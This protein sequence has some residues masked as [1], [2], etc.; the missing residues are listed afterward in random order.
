MAWPQQGQ[1]K[2]IQL[3]TC[4]GIS[5]CLAQFK[6]DFARKTNLNN[7]L[8]EERTTYGKS[9]GRWEDLQNTMDTSSVAV[10]CTGTHA[11]TQRYT[12]VSY[13]YKLHNVIIYLYSRL[14]E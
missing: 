11:H 7:E 6:H 2:R 14:S 1:S 5:H 9:A 8:S 3:F 12:R 13:F 4:A 10:K